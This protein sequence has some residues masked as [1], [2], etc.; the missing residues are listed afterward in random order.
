ML[1]Q[2]AGSRTDASSDPEASSS[3]SSG[4]F[5]AGWTVDGVRGLLESHIIFA[6]LISN[7][8][9]GQVPGH[10]DSFCTNAIASESST[11]ACNSMWPLR[12]WIV[13]LNPR[14]S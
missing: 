12:P 6:V 14:T 3:S 4:A 10:F 8:D 2:T 7:A 11:A 9:D 13:R 1:K 5:C